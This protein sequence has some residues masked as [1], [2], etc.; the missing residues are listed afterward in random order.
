MKSKLTAVKDFWRSHQFALFIIGC[1]AFAMLMTS[2]SLWLYRQS[3]AMK[4]DMSRPGYEKVRKKVEKSQDDESYP[5]SGKIDEKAEADFKKR[6]QKYQ[7]D[8][9]KMGTFDDSATD[10][11]SLDLSNP[12]EITVNSDDSDL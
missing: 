6:L 8:L 12:G 9:K 7:N 3:G 2:V 4:L 10:D 5:S 1:I 11:E